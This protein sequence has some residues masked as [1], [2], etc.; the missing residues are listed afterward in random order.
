MRGMPE[1]YRK[2]LGLASHEYFH[3]W[4]V[5]RIKPQAFVP[6]DLERENYTR[7]LWIFEGFTSYY[8]DLMLA[9]AGVIGVDDYLKA[10]GTTV[11]S[12]LRAPGRHEQS[13][14][15]SSFDAWIKYYRQDENS[16][17]VIVSY[18]AK[19][20]LVA[21][22]LDLTIRALTRGARSLDDVMRLLWQRYGR[23]FETQP[24]GLEED[25]FPALLAEAT[26]LDLSR[27]IRTWTGGTDELP[28][29]RLLKG[30]GVALDTRTADEGAPWLGVRT[31]P[32]G[33]DLVVG[34]ALAG[35]PAQGAGLSAGDVLVAVDG[36]RADDKTLKAVLAR[37]RPGDRLRVHAFRHGALMEFELVLATAPATEAKLRLDTKAPAGARRQRQ[38]WLGVTE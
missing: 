8:D 20:A 26:G 28:L 27:Q 14:A 6:Y 35:G 33:A 19:G 13:V 36:L 18:Y 3:S 5:K 12:V 25:A 17:N 24:A 15:E 7:L 9:R 11:S 1:G 21:L 23:T 38:A 37:R 34:T 29:A 32:R 2:F 4:N 16:P 22:C 31:S 30:V 10:L